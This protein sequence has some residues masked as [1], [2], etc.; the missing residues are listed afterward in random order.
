VRVN[1]AATATKALAQN[2][3]FSLYSGA[4]FSSS[5]QTN[6]VA[7]K[8]TSTILPV[9]NTQTFAT[10]DAQLFTRQNFNTIGDT[11][12][13]GVT[14][15]WLSQNKSRLDVQSQ[16]TAADPADFYQF[17][18]QKGDNL[19]LAFN[20][21]TSLAKATPVR[22][23]LLDATGAQVLADSGGTTAQKAAYAALTSSTGLNAK[24]AQYVVKV[25]YAPGADHSKTQNY[26][27]QVYSGST[28]ATSYQT[29]ASAQT[30][31]NA[32]LT[33][34]PNVTGF[35]P[36]AAA[37]SYLQSFSQG[38]APDIFSALSKLV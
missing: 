23:Q 32:I 24:P 25:A 11:A 12:T 16:L 17:T 10:S 31:G 28:Y 35:N 6:A 4:E 22:V 3:S 30:F 37:A 1:Y 36:N 18:L 29:I 38:T 34:N 20:N 2:Y 27:F 14:I 9:D 33:G 7:Q 26:N 5:Y 8:S 15:G 19:K 13:T 21:T